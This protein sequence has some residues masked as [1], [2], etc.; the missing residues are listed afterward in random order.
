MAPK[1]KT[2]GPVTAK[3]GNG[4]QS[5]AK[6]NGMS[7]GFVRAGEDVHVISVVAGEP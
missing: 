7:V 5:Q 1:Q 3:G 2:V 4:K 6:G